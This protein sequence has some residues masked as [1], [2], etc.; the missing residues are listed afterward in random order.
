MSVATNYISIIAE[1]F[2]VSISV[3]F[4]ISSQDFYCI[5]FLL[6]SIYTISA[7]DNSFILS[8]RLPTRWIS[9]SWQP[10]V[11]YRV[12]ISYY[13]YIFCAVYI[14]V[15]HV[16]LLIKY[17]YSI[18]AKA[19]PL[20]DTER[21]RVGQS[22]VVTNKLRFFTL[23]EKKTTCGLSLKCK[24]VGLLALMEFLVYVSLDAKLTCPCNIMI[25]LWGS[26]QGQ[27]SRWISFNFNHMLYRF[28]PCLQTFF[29]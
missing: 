28:Q 4:C 29:K 27:K 17:L 12:L 5:A 7:W 2:I 19:T 10:S 18:L 25:G 26:R 6:L 16:G 9:V 20:R 8:L 24:T 1:Y 14:I 11:I 23:S 22:Q 15:V 13:A 21:S 3:F